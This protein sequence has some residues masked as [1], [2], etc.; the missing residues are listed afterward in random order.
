MFGLDFREGESSGGLLERG[1]AILALLLQMVYNRL[2]LVST[3]VQE[4][5]ERFWPLLVWTLVSVVLISF[6]VLFLSLWII[7]YFWSSRLIAVGVVAGVYLFAGVLLVAYVNSLWSRR[8]KLFE[9]SLAE[10]EK[11]LHKLR[12]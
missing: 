9:T 1:K 10:L 11:D 7:L 5:Y 2:E 12:D 8:S 4:E 6:A 3:E